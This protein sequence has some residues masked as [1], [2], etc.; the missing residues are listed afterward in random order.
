MGTRIF[1]AHPSG[2][3][4]V[5]VKLDPRATMW[6]PRTESPADFPS[7]SAVELP[8]PTFIDASSASNQPIQ[9]DSFMLRLSPSQVPLR[10]PM[11]LAMPLPPS[12][13]IVPRRLGMASLWPSNPPAPG[14][15]LHSFSNSLFLLPSSPRPLPLAPVIDDILALLRLEIGL[16]EAEVSACVSAFPRLAKTPVVSARAVLKQFERW[17]IMR[18]DLRPLL[19]QSPRLLAQPLHLIRERKHQLET[20]GIRG[21]H[22]LRAVLQRHVSVFSS[23]W[24]AALWDGLKQAI[25]AG[26]D[27]CLALDLRLASS[28][29]QSRLDALHCA[30]IATPRILR[31]SPKLLSRPEA[32]VQTRIALLESLGLTKVHV[33]A[34]LSKEPGL[35]NLGPDGLHAR[36]EFFRGLG[37]DDAD[38][39]LILRRR[40][41]VFT[42]SVESYLEPNV[43]FW[44]DRGLTD[45]DLRKMLRRNPS[46]LGAYARNSLHGHIVF[47][48]RAGLS[49]TDALQV[50]V[51]QPTLLNLTTDSL[52]SR[53]SFFQRLGVRDS[54]L[55]SL[56]LREP[57]MLAM[58]V[59]KNLQPTLAVLLE[60]GY[61]RADV[62]R[63]PSALKYSLTNRI[64]PRLALLRHLA[65]PLEPLSALLSPSD[66]VF[67]RRNG[68]TL[69]EYMAFMNRDSS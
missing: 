27:P 39:A 40:P 31:R 32:F 64:W 1:L 20:A 8:A 36:I 29:I 14:Y 10:L 69:A 44:R 51:R 50:L 23:S 19:P 49:P 33:A 48:T 42:C 18:E 17:G 28:K 6:Q 62:A 4:E 46:I 38:L 26:A 7:Q 56:C 54:S 58:S 63:F 37:L 24:S 55:A 52:A 43:Q 41:A 12:S 5:V 13:S 2:Q 16:S 9:S 59:E 67:A 47:L 22:A 15:S 3:Q 21:A 68:L 60:H 11:R 66:E 53:V 35:I 30:G 25:D 57:A 45:S 65:R 34:I 61:S